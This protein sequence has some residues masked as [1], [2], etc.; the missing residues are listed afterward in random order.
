MNKEYEGASWNG[1]TVRHGYIKN[2]E[3]NRDGGAGIRAFRGVE[4]ENMVVVN[5]YTHGSR[6]RGGGLYMDG[7]NS[8]ISNSFIVENFCAGSES[9][10]GGAYMIVGTGFNMV[11]ANNHSQFCGG[12]LFIESATFYNN[13]VAYNR[14]G[15]T[16]GDG[17][18]SGI[19]QYADSGSGRLSSLGLYNCIFYGN[20]GNPNSRNYQ[21]ASNAPTTFDKPYNCYVS[22]SIGS[23]IVGRF[24]TDNVYRN[25]VGTNLANPFEL[26]NGAQSVNNYRLAPNSTCLNNGTEKLG[27]DVSIP[28]TD[29][30]YTNRIKD[31]TIDIGAYESDNEENIKNEAH[32]SSQ[33]ALPDQRR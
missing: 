14:T 28:S 2:Y 4:L 5:N 27:N 3:A 21:I 16:L 11:V 32:S 24:V 8:V 1:F 30:D 7:L 19:F 10:G 22:G 12:G 15:G 18:G 26:G 23:N 20:V 33:G 25:Q 13:T 9:Y 6:S 29:I 17:N 31:C